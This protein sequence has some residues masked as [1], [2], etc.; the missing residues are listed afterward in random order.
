MNHASHKNYKIRLY[1]NSIHILLLLL[2]PMKRGVENVIRLPYGGQSSL[3]T[4]DES[5]LSTLGIE[6]M[7]NGPS[8]HFNQHYQSKI[9]TVADIN[10]KTKWKSTHC[11]LNRALPSDFKFPLGKKV[12]LQSGIL[13]KVLSPYFCGN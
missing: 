7:V 5:L 10:A 1:G 11:F 2:T 12:K 13:Q 4:L 3:Y 9:L 8:E 6:H